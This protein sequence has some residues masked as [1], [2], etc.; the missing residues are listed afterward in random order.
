MRAEP[1]EHRESRDVHEMRKA[2]CSVL[3]AVCCV[4]CDQQLWAMCFVLR[5]LCCVLGAL[6]QFVWFAACCV[7]GLWWYALCFVNLVST[8]VALSEA[9]AASLARRMR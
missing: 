3:R 9:S 8:H 2:V 7:C 4:L 6:S 1:G 5:A